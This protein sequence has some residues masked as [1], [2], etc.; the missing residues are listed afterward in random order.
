MNQVGLCKSVLNAIKASLSDFPSLEAFPKYQRCS[1]NYW[2]GIYYFLQ[3]D[4]TTA[5]TNLTEAFNECYIESKHNQEYV[6]HT[7]LVAFSQADLTRLIL[8]YLIPTRLAH[9]QLLPSQN[10]LSKYPTL[11][12][13]FTP[14]FSA[15]RRG[16]LRDFDAALL[17]AEDTFVS[18]RIFLTLEKGR[19]ICLRNALRK[20]W[21]CLDEDKRQKVLVETFRV[22]LGISSGVGAEGIDGE[23]VECLL[24]NMIAGVSFSDAIDNFS[25]DANGSR[26]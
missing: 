15:I 6:S 4:Y 13:L 11:N 24:T 21:L 3:G 22:G 23:E 2:T 1:Y 17:A 10:F 19:E 16:S 14:I 20:T 7:T 8:T 5:E 25:K 26:V 12:K 9:H 18:K